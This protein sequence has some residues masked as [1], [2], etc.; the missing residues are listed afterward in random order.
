MVSCLV[1]EN[2]GASKVKNSGVELMGPRV[3]S[4][5]KTLG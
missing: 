4:D 5:I 3:W 2:D 1:S